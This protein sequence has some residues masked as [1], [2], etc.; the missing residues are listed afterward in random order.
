MTMKHAIIHVENTEGIVDFA[1]FLSESGWTIFSANKTEDL[2]KK[3]KIPVTRE[4]ALQESNT[5][6]NDTAEL[7]QKI[8]S[9]S[10]NE[11]DPNYSQSNNI[12]LICMNVLPMLHPT[13]LEKRLNTTSKP[14][15][16]YISTI[17][18]TAFLNYENILILTD[19]DDYKEAIIQL[20]TDSITPEFRVYL[21]AKALNLVSAFDGGLASSVLMKSEKNTNFMRYLTYPF[22]LYSPLS[23]GTNKHQEAGLY[24][25][26]NKNGIN[27]SIPKEVC[28]KIDFNTIADI[29]FA[30]EQISML[31]QNLKN[32]FSVKSTTCDGYNYVTQ[33]TPFTGTVFTLIVKYKSILGAAL[34]TNVLDSFK[35]AYSYDTDKIKNTVLASSAV[36]DE[37]AAQEIVKC[38]L[39]AVIAPG[40]T[41]DA[42]KILSS[43]EN[44][45][46]IPMTKIAALDFELELIGGGILF[47]TKDST[48]FEHWD[49]KTKNR[50]HQ[51][52]IDEMAFGTILSM[53]SRSYSA[54]LL[55]NNAVVGI[56]QACK[57]SERAV[58]NAFSEAISY[59][60]HYSFQ[61][62]DDN[63]IADVLVC[64]SSIS[65][66]D[67]V[68][69][70]I[71]KGLTAIIHTGD[72]PN[73]QD[74][75]DY[76]NDHNVSLI[77][78][79]MSHISF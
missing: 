64:D 5:Y 13:N 3:E 65:L 15:N 50:P 72:R 19:P 77:F 34:E 14:F 37:T 22:E 12:T 18:R 57:T 66:C 36:I 68:R 67:S 20:K 54:V 75:I 21:A 41:Q 8:I 28:D 73:S 39:S 17:L 63:R 71:D 24:T 10:C 44:I 4:H 60:N 45:I 29:S 16:F 48:L 56:S 69:E 33:F 9:S 1:R 52:I 59:T 30:W 61:N 53:G 40:F 55:K 11:N 32:Q 35:N 31:S 76:C 23:Y 79:G 2:L 43:N 58:A 7:I 26:L 70:L 49:V 42:K 62:N 38:D 46:L 74:L 51:N 6:I 27:T 25:F 47:Q 78:T